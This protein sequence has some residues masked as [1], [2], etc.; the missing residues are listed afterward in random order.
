MNGR[1][2]SETQQTIAEWAEETFGAAHDPAVLVDRA[3]I[4]L[5]ELREALAAN[6]IAEIGKE[7]ADVAILLYRL[8]EMHGLDLQAEIDAKMDE[9]RGRRWRPKGDGT[10]SHIK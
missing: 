8:M 7:T 5:A 1:S 9:N 3:A 4:E 2:V 10:G 6:Q